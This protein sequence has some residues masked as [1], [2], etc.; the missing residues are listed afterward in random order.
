M[1]QAG[2]SHIV[3]FQ[4]VTLDRLA[5]LAGG[6]RLF[7]LVPAFPGVHIPHQAIALLLLR[8]ERRDIVDI[9]LWG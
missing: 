8:P 1:R 9:L 3:D 5:I 2:E 4:P 7:D 6:L